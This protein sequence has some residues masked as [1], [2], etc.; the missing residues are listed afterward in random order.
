MLEWKM[1]LPT[2]TAAHDSI[3]EPVQ[4]GKF[5]GPV[6]FLRGARSGYITDADLPIIQQHFPKAQ[7]I[8][9]PNA[10]HWVHADQPQALIEALV[11]FLSS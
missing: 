10:G 1:N 11:Q 6:L 7:V 5:E 8:T 3:L 9:I 2:L 4:G